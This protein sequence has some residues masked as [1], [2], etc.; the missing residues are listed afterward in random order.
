MI[1]VTRCQILRLKPTKIDFG[2]GAPLQALLR[3]L[4]ALD[5]QTS[6]W[7]KGDLGLL[8][9][10]RGG[11]RREGRAVGRGRE[12]KRDEGPRVYL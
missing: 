2:W 3:E 10:G 8:L 6:S 5:P 9:G 4:A 7:N 12:G 1:L 11:Q